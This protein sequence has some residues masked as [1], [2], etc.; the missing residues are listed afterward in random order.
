MLYGRSLAV[1]LQRRFRLRQILPQ[2]NLVEVNARCLYQIQMMVRY[3]SMAVARDNHRDP[4][5]LYGY[6]NIVD[7]ESDLLEYQELKRGRVLHLD[8]YR[9]NLEEP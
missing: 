1:N 3:L 2:T 8:K 9:Y 4:Y 5:Q 7:L 6:A